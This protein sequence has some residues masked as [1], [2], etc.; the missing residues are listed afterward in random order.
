MCLFSSILNLPRVESR[1]RGKSRNVSETTGENNLGLNGMNNERTKSQL[2]STISNM[3]A[4]IKFGEHQK[5]N[6][7]NDC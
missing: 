4:Y 6:V 1:V 7:K 2:F 3:N 5:L